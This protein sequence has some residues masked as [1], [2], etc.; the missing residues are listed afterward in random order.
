MT[1]SEPIIEALISL[2]DDPDEVIINSVKVKLYSLGSSVLPHLEDSLLLAES[3]E[4]AKNLEGIISHLKREVLIE[5]MKE[6]IGNDNRTLTDGWLLV[7]S[8]HH[9]N[10]SK[11][12]IEINLQKI[13]RDI[14]LEITESMTSLEKVA[15]INHI[16]FKINGFDISNSDAPNVDHI[17]LDK[18]LFS[19]SGD[20]YSLTILYLIIARYLHLDLLPIMLANKL[21]L[22]YE[23]NLA[24][25]LAFGINSDKYL[26]YINVAHRGSII[27]PKELQFLYDK[28]QKYGKIITRIETDISLIKKLLN[29]MY[30][31]YTNDGEQD[32]LLLTEDLLALL[33]SY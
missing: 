25:S 12:K 23:D 6:W 8:I 28:S 29:L 11:E 1:T 10:I 7:S 14:W 27:S 19:K 33:E 22:V 31:I 17:V 21:L 3:V 4:R 24:A 32:K 13:Y 30:L 20:V 9:P 15:V 16:L 2:L 5:R 18:M 26:F